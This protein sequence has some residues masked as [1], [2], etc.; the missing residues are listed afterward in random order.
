MVSDKSS[1]SKSLSNLVV[2]PDILAVVLA[3]GA[4]ARLS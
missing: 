3:L 2:E 1:H 4:L